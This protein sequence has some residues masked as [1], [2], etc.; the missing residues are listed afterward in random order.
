M[1]R[2]TEFSVVL[3]VICLVVFSWPLLSI[4]GVESPRSMYCYLFFMWA[5]VILLLFLLG[6][7]STGPETSKDRHS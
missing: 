7:R 4:P 5:V 2:Q 1:L 3:F 6:L